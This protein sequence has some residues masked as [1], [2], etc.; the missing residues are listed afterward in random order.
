MRRAYGLGDV[1][2]FKRPAHLFRGWPRAAKF[3]SG[4]YSKAAA[5][6]QS[7]LA[8]SDRTKQLRVES[9]EGFV[10]VGLLLSEPAREF[11]RRPDV[12]RL[13]SVAGDG[14]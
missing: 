5:G 11:D 8:P 4:I 3:T 9:W 10:S 1:L 12:M 2:C 13:S 7:D 6:G 14:D